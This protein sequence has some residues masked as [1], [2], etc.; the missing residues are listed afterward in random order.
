MEIVLLDYWMKPTI[1]ID[2]IESAIWTKRFNKCGD[3]EVKLPLSIL[4]D[5]EIKHHQ[6]I[7]FPQSGDYMLIESLQLDTDSEKGDTITIK[8]RTYDSILD[9]RIIQNR[10][11][12]NVGMIYAVYSLLSENVLNPTNTNRKMNEVGW[13]WPQNMPNDKAG[14][15]NAQY[16]GDNLLDVIQKLCQ[17]RNVGY[18][19]PYVPKGPADNKYQFQLYW[20]HERHFTQKKN[21]YVIFSP[22]YDNLR[23]TKFLTSTTKEKNAALV[24]GAGEE[25]NRKRLWHENGVMSGWLRKELYVDAKDVREKDENNKDIPGDKY[26]EL[27]RQKGR[28]K[29]VD[30][31]VTSVYDGEMSQTSQFKFGRD[32]DLGDVVQIQNGLGMM[33]VG[34]CTEYIRSFTSSDG[35][36]EYPTFET[37]YIP[38]E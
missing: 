3:F 27:L 21:P 17:E 34:R 1:I 31:I 2:Q 26:W 7:Y 28:E 23:K 9:R 14:W 6:N 36:K 24:A 11:I 13:L 37:Y 5:T 15:V 16:T 38:Q 25:P 20:G 10:T 4:L 30:C 22:D 35:W 8:G 33:N 18:W 32:F 19:M 29:L 12:L